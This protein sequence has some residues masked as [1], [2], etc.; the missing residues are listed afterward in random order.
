MGAAELGS[1]GDVVG[2][3]LYINGMILTGNV[4]GALT[5]EWAGSSTLSANAPMSAGSSLRAKAWMGGGVSIL[6]ASIVV[7]GYG[8][9]S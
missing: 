9:A 1:L 4:S 7:I 3:P 5:G 6:F 2:W 8:N